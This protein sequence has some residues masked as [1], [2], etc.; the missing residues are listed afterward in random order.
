MNYVADREL[1][2]FQVVRQQFNT[3]MVVLRL[4]LINRDL[5]YQIYIAGHLVSQQCSILSKLPTIVTADAVLHMINAIHAAYICVGNFDD[6]FIDLARIRKGSSQTINRSLHTL[7]NHSVLKLM[8]QP[9]VP[10]L[11]ILVVRY[12]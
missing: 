6:R 9:T 11:D 12:C 4:I 1:Q 7:M 3:S 2:C 8:K 5:T 10:R